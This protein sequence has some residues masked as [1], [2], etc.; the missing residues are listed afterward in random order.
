MYRNYIKRLLDLLLSAVAAVV[1]A[2]PMAILAIW[3]KIDSRARCF[4]SSGGWGPT[5]PISTF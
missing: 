5:R 1:L 4:S 3:I 2:I